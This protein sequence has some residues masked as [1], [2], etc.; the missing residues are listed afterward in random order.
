[1]KK[2]FNSDC[3][4]ASLELALTL[5][6]KKHLKFTPGIKQLI[7]E[8]RIFEPHTYFVLAGATA[9]ESQTPQS[10]MLHYRAIKH[11]WR[12]VAVVMGMPWSHIQ[13]C[14]S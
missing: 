4:A 9:A 13:T 12:A 10:L 6:L 5:L 11:Q 8:Q 1:M 3:G 2:V 7:L 14:T